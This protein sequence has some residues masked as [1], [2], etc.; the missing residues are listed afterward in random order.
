M[1]DWEAACRE[2]AAADDVLGRLIL[3]YPNSRLQSRGAPFETLVRSIVGQQISVKAADAVWVRV[4]ACVGE[5]IPERVARVEGGV[6]RACGLSEAK[7][8]YVRGVACGFAE[9]VVKPEAWRTMD[10]EAVIAEL[11]A[12]PGI[13][14]WSAEMFL[15]F[16]LLRPDVLPIGDLGLVKGFKLA[17]GERWKRDADTKVWQRRLRRHAVVWAPYRSV[18]TWY[19]WRSLDPN[20]VAY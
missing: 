10:D 16:N 18:A 6:L 4:K 20:E 5:M 2:L 14:R 15:M 3:R 9:G 7:V 17:Y 13:G 8:R 12:L 19:L 1:L 11:T